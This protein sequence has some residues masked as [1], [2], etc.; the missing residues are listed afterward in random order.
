MYGGVL[1]G[2]LNPVYHSRLRSEV[3]LYFLRSIT[4]GNAKQE[5]AHGQEEDE[6]LELPGPLDPFAIGNIRHG[7]T[8]EEDGIG[9]DNGIGEAVCHAVGQ[10]D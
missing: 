3:W 8:D 6:E 10:D 5:D 9:G 7:Q 4:D 2:W 1:Q